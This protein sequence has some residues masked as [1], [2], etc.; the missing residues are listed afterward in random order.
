MNVYMCVPVYER[1]ST[2]ISDQARW[3]GE[4]KTAQSVNRFSRAR[5]RIKKKI[6][7]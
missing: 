5:I 7:N 2:E 1:L 3:G 4:N 6:D